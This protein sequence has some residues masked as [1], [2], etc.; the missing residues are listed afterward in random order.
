[1]ESLANFV[2]HHVEL[3]T[4]LLTFAVVAN[5]IVFGIYKRRHGLPP[6]RRTGALLVLVLGSLIIFA[7]FCVGVMTTHN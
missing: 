5:A 7:G 6:S 3:V 4:N 1:M 2:S